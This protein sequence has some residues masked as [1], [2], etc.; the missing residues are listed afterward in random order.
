[1]S[2]Q[3]FDVA[4]TKTACPA[5]GRSWAGDI[6]LN[7]RSVSSKRVQELEGK[8][9]RFEMCSTCQQVVDQGGMLLVEIDPSKSKVEGDT[10]APQN[11]WRT[12]RYWG[13]SGDAAKRIFKDPVPVAFIDSTIVEAIGLPDPEPAG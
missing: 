2:R 13:I 11:A 9:T 4:L 7:T 8:I 6:V 12:G 1:M 10:I 3:G 5:C